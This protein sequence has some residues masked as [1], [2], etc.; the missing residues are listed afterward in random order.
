MPASRLLRR[1]V[2]T[3]DVSIQ[4]LLVWKTNKEAFGYPAYAA[5]W[6]SFSPNSQEQF[7]VDMRISNSETQI[8]QLAE[9]FIAKNIKAGWIKE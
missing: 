1:E 4:K 7:K 8:K 2:W 9:Q 3:K 6:T 5:S